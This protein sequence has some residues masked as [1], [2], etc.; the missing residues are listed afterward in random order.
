MEEFI[1]IYTT[2]PHRRQARRLSKNLIKEKLIAC[3][4]IFKIDSLYLW[5]GKLEEAREYGVFLKT[6][7]TLY[8]KVEEKI[9]N[10]HPY[11]LPCI[12]SWKLGEGSKEFLDWIKENTSF[13]K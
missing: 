4:N 13:K 1:I 8:S 6:R 3:A 7:A 10:Y 12:I 9:K 2:F 11:E 5:E